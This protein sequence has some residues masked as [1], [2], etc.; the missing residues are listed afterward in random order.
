[1]EN[2]ACLII[3][4][5]K[6]PAGLRGVLLLFSTVSVGLHHGVS[7]DHLSDQLHCVVQQFS[8]PDLGPGCAFN[9]FELSQQ[10]TGSQSAFRQRRLHP[11]NIQNCVFS[12]SQT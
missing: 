6:W 8:S 1:M 3:H 12:P 11:G 7:V 2:K 5:I 9:L 10:V 4:Q